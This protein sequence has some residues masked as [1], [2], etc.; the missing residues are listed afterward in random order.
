MLP[1]LDTKMEIPLQMIS[2]RNM[3]MDHEN[4]TAP[5]HERPAAFVAST[6][7]LAFLAGC[8]SNARSLDTPLTI[9]SLALR[10]PVESTVPRLTASG[11]HA[12]VSW[13]ES[14]DTTSTLRYAERTASGWSDPRTAASGTDW[15]LSSADLPTVMRLADG[16]LVAEWLKSTDAAADAYDLLIAFSH[17][18]GRT[19]AAPVSPHHDGTKTQHGFAAMF[20]QTAKGFGLVWLDGRQTAAATGGGD[21]MSLRAAT[22]DATGRQTSDALI[23]DRV[24]DCCPTSIAVTVDGPIVAFRDRSKEE[25][26]DIAVSRLVNGAWTAPHTVHADGW[27]IHGCPVNG[28]AIAASGRTVVVAWFTAPNDQGRA[29]AAF[30][31]DAGAS[32]GQP[33]RLDDAQTI[34]RVDVALL[35]DGAAVASWIEPANGRAELRIRR[36]HASGAR[37][38]AQ[39]VASVGAPRTSGYPR[40]IRHGDELLFAWTETQST[41]KTA[42]A[43]LR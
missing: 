4:T 27:Q 39:T 20:E 8:T 35:D 6:C 17:D 42:A 36:V 16:T 31:Q 40:L 12:I 33:I 26:R 25:I 43:R 3:K 29:F 30:S 37:A 15:F 41:V 2:R 1:G 5:N 21:N 19:W 9:E 10:A 7:L 32:F 14:G 38:A 23:D 13:V 18:E 28:P 22:F 24:C 11:D 34:G